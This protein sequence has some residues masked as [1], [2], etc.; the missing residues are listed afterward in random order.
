M[1]VGNI[2][3]RKGVLFLIKNFHE[4]SKKFNLQEKFL[5]VG[6]IQ[7]L[8]YFNE[9]SDYINK[10]NI[11]NIDFLDS[12]LPDDLSNIYSSFLY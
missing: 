2:I 6:E 8:D 4:Y 1:Y 11:D 12:Q 3:P 10:N 9:C 5:I 7:N